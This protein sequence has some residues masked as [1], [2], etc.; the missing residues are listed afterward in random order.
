MP[1]DPPD[2]PGPLHG[3][4]SM[5]GL[6]HVEPLDDATKEKYQLTEEEAEIVALGA[7]ILRQGFADNAENED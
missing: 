3:W 1:P 4:A 2:Q 7:A 5:F 6:D